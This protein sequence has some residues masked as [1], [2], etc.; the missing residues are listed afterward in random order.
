M[1]FDLKQMLRVMDELF[2][3]VHC[4]ALVP[5]FDP[6]QL[7]EARLKIN[8]ETNMSSTITQVQSA[9]SKNVL[10]HF[11]AML[12]FETDCSGLHHAITE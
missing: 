10:A 11:E 7:S 2:P 6:E 5:K 12:R 1:A 3:T 8:Q 9:N 4:R